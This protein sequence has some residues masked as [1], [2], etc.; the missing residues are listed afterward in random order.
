MK[1][2]PVGEKIVVK[3]LDAEE[4]TSGGIVLPDVAQKRPRQGRVLSVGDGHLLP[5]GTR[6]PHQVGEGDRILFARFSGRYNCRSFSFGGRGCGKAED[7]FFH[8]GS[9]EYRGH[10]PDRFDSLPFDDGD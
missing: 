3:R 7:C 10:P 1:L 8:V 5:D 2:V 6:A 4:K 9:Q